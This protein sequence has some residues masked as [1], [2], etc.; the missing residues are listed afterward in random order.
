MIPDSNVTGRH[1]GMKH[2]LLTQRRHETGH[3]MCH[4]SYFCLLVGTWHPISQRSVWY[5]TIS[6][7]YV[8]I[9]SSDIILI[10]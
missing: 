10:P 4:L 7:R 5:C 3:A 9:Q 2:K 8:R 6:L 1:R